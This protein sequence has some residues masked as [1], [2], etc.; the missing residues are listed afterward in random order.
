MK[1]IIGALIAIVI[2]L[3][4]WYYQWKMISVHGVNLRNW[5]VIGSYSNSNEAAELLSRAHKTLIQFMRVLETKY[6][7]DETDDTIAMEGSQHTAIVNSRGDVYNCVDTLL[8]NYNP[9]R[10]FENDPKWNKGTSYTMNKGESMYV[11]LRNRDDP[12]KLID[13][14]T[15]LFVLLHE[16]SHIANYNGWGHST[17]FWEVFAFILH[18]AQLAGLYTPINY[19]K[20]PVMYCGLEINYSPLFDPSLK[21]IWV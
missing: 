21:K 2:I 9:D 3:S 1:L 6:H 4:V 10:I 17:R 7:I 15:L 20:Y 18:E 16:I 12:S 5:N 19:E 14:D 11:C 8:N 13:F